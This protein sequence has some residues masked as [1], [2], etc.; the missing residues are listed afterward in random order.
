[1]L[2]R[3]ETVLGRA[4]RI[5]SRG[6]DNRIRRIAVVVGEVDDQIRDFPYRSVLR[7]ITLSIVSSPQVRRELAGAD[8]WPWFLKP[9]LSPSSPRGTS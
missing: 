1:M 2:I 9:A 8:G 3:K 5:C 4:S 6:Q 7:A